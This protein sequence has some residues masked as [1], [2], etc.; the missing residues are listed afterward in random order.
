MMTISVII[1]TFNRSQLLNLVLEDL[2]NQ[3]LDRKLFEVII[4]DNNSNDNTESLVNEFCQINDINIV[5]CKEYK[6]GVSHARNRG[7]F[8]SKSSY[9]AY[10]DDDCRIPK[11]W[12]EKAYEIILLMSPD[13]FGG[14]IL[15]IYSSEKPSWY[16]DEY[17]MVSHGNQKIFFIG[18]EFFSGGNMIFRKELLIKA[19]GFDTNVGPIGKKLGHAEEDSAQIRIKKIKPDAKFYYD[20][21]LEVTHNVSK[22]KIS[23]LWPFKFGFSIGKSKE[24]LNQL[25]YPQDIKKYNFLEFF[26]NIVYILLTYIKE[27]VSDLIKR[28]KKRFPFIENII[29][30]R[31]FKFARKI[32]VLSKKYHD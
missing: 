17:A 23:L 27:I 20:P 13:V 7:V 18:N 28:D 9:I 32:G 22:N 6:Q 4:I 30:E 5:Y 26:K 24:Y 1:C 2:V 15:P 31:S 29:Y 14:P 3:T 8:E 11:N 12:L 10:T 19:G 16:K 25:D 21:E